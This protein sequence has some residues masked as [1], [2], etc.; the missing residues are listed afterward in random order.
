MTN[1]RRTTAA[2]LAGAIGLAGSACGGSSK[3]PAATTTGTGAA[4]STTPTSNKSKRTPLSQ[5]PATTQ[6]F[7]GKGPKELGVVRIP[8]NSTL[9]W[10]DDGMPATRLFQIIPAS[11]KVQS[12]VNSRAGSG[13]API[14]KGAY[15]GFL[16]NA[17]GNDN[18]TL[19][20]VPG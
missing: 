19:T 13:S 3:K 11:V 15:H 7:S 8:T 4:T 16:V 2:L 6:K 10:T 12:P 14:K 1:P 5:T 20:I 18:W 9:K 17:N